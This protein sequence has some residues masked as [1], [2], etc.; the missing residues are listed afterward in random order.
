[1]PAFKQNKNYTHKPTIM[2]PIHWIVSSAIMMF[3]TFSQSF[4]KHD[5]DLKNSQ[6]P[7]KNSSNKPLAVGITF[8]MEPGFLAKKD[9]ATY[10]MIDGIEFRVGVH[11]DI[12][13]L[14]MLNSNDTRQIL[15]KDASVLVIPAGQEDV[16]LP[17]KK[18]YKAANIHAQ[19]FEL[20]D[21]FGKEGLDFSSFT[22]L[23]E[24]TPAYFEDKAGVVRWVYNPVYFENA[25]GVDSV[26]EVLC[27]APLPRHDSF[28]VYKTAEQQLNK[29]LISS[30]SQSKNKKF[31]FGIQYN[32]LEP[33]A[34]SVALFRKLAARIS[35][36][37]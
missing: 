21:E 3:F 5:F 15:S 31:S 12:Q 2:Q 10:Y 17:N 13:R 36:Q 30:V 35:M 37:Q 16:P 11:V 1:M 8:Q 24:S 34:D 25:F 6:E 23:N 4:S 28:Y 7:R 9:T 20:P 19:P 22:K 32:Y 26:T 33:S 29:R 14:P 27:F 18:V